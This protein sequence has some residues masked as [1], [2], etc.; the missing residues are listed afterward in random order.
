MADNE[1]VEST[2]V[3]DV[4]MGEEEGAPAADA[5]EEQGLTELEPDVPKLVLFAE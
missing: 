5:S 4:Q 2:P 3:E 1:T